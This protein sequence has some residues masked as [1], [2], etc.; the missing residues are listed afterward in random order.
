MSWDNT[1]INYDQDGEPDDT[2]WRQDM[3]EERDER[4]RDINNGCED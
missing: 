4:S 1:P 3:N 2:Q